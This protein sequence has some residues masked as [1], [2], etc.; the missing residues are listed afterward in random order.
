MASGFGFQTRKLQSEAD[1]SFHLPEFHL[2]EVLFLI[3]LKSL[4]MSMYHN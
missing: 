1:N 3:F 4:Y 2:D